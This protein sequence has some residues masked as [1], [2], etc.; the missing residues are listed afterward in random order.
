[1]ASFKKI[2]ANYETILKKILK[3]LRKI[4]SKI[5]FIPILGNFFA[6]KKIVAKANLKK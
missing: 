5:N 6:N 4:P 2:E 1:M 3:N